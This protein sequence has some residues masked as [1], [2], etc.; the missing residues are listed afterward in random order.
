[1]SY[2]STG[3]VFS[4]LQTRMMAA[5]KPVTSTVTPSAAQ[6]AA[7][8]AKGMIWVPAKG[9]VRGH[10]E[11]KRSTTSTRTVTVRHTPASAMSPQ[12]L[13]ERKQMFQGLQLRNKCKATGMP[14]EFLEMCA[15]GLKEGASLEQ[16][17]EAIHAQAAAQAQ[18]QAPAAQPGIAPVAPPK[19]KFPTLLVV[20]AGGGL[21][22][23]FLL[24][25]RKRK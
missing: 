6:K 23:V 8:G 13:A 21:L 17:N 7:M 22:A 12:Q 2:Q 1:M 24:L 5:V 11:R 4:N 16:V 3:S 19:K 14:A 9:S 15:Q 18:A 20:A 10:W 25:R